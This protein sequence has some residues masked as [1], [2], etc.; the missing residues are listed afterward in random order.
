[1][2]SREASTADR[3]KP[4]LDMDIQSEITP[5]DEAKLAD[6]GSEQGQASTQDAATSANQSHTQHAEQSGEAGVE[7]EEVSGP[8]GKKAP[9]QQPSGN[10]HQTLATPAVRHL[11]K[12]HGLDISDI[13]G[14]GKDGRVLKEDVQ[15]H[16]SKPTS[17]NQPTI[18]GS[19]SAAAAPVPVVGSSS[20]S[21]SSRQVPLTPVQN[22]MFKT[23]TASLQI[24]HFLYTTPTNLNALNRWRRTINHS[25]PEPE[26]K[27]TPLP[28][29]VKAVSTALH[30]H[31]LLNASLHTTTSSSP[32]LTYHDSH[33][34]G[35]AMDTPSGLLVPV[36]HNVQLL[37]IKE[38]STKIKELSV[39]AREGRL[40][41]EEME[42]ATFTISN[43]GSIGG[44]V[45]APVIVAPQVAILGVGRARVVPVFEI[46]DDG[47]ERVIKSEESVFSWSA[48]HRVVDGAECA[49]AAE[50]LKGY[51]ENFE[52]WTAELR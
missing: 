27:L 16:M 46:G 5:E 41:R 37:S 24:P 32:T 48:D 36:V 9:G 26:L 8:L 6:T 20:S 43:I 45:V 14:S 42:G 7:R 21:T 35:I 34:I 47:V 22:A 19:G 10:K 25:N 23:M 13:R 50:R 40:K 1:M 3:W 51:L 11:T 33:N 12:E 38:I 15:K 52:T 29:I 31:P 44:G 49:R 30:H 4:L 17:T 18:S 28:F 39:K 2:Q